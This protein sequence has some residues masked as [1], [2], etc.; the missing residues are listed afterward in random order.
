MK[1]IQVQENRTILIALSIVCLVV[2]IIFILYNQELQHQEEVRQTELESL[3]LETEALENLSSGNLNVILYF[4]KP[5]IV[6]EDPDLF[7]SDELLISETRT[8]F[9]TDDLTLTARQIIHEVLKGSENEESLQIFSDE[10]RLRQVYLQEDGTALVD[11]SQGLLPPEIAGVAVELAAIYSITRS[12]TSN[13][14]EIQRI[15]FLVEGREHPTLAGH[16]SI[17]DPFM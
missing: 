5:N 14:G 10:A 9:D 15:K 6:F 16:V 3:D 4:Y 2:A 11:L 7:S 1:K 8:I 17:H 12:L 13:I